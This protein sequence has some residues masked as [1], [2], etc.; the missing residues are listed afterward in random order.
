MKKVLFALIIA[1]ALIAVS[2]SDYNV[3]NDLCSVQFGRLEAKA[4]SSGVTGVV[5]AAENLYWTYTAKK[6]E[7]DKGSKTGE[8]RYTAQEITNINSAEGVQESEKVS[9]DS[10]K[11][12]PIKASGAGYTETLGGFA[13]GEWEF[14]IYGYLEQEHTN[15]IYKGT[16][17]SAHLVVNKVATVAFNVEIQDG[18][19]GTLITKAPGTVL[20]ADYTVTLKSATLTGATMPEHT[21][22]FVEPEG[23]ADAYIATTE[24][25]KQGLW[26]LVYQFED[27]SGNSLGDD[28]EVDAL[29]LNGATTTVTL[30]YDGTLCKWTVQSVTT[31][32]DE[33]RIVWTQ[34]YVPTNPTTTYPAVIPKVGEVLTYGTYPANY[35]NSSGSS[36]SAGD[37]AGKDVTW[38]V[39]AVENGRALVVSEKVLFYM[40]PKAEATTD[41]TSYIYKWSTNDINTYLNGNFLTDYGLSNVKIPSVSHT[42]EAGKDSSTQPAEN[43]TEKVFLLSKAEAENASYFADNVARRVADLSGSNSNWLLRSPSSNMAYREVS[44]G[45]WGE[46][47]PYGQG[48]HLYKG[49]RPAF[50]VTY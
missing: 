47:E 39:L 30:Q 48:M 31:P 37:Y 17:T 5:A 18:S 14:T 15:L 46:M 35:T 7:N 8:T 24:N 44:V 38:K 12:T 42:T 20:D 21:F 19:K 16:C 6:T 49:V 23:G 50:W 29:I 1:V 22:T 10:L 9:A 43:S 2:C 28:L 4:G 27:K 25:V 11:E 32:Q 45:T 3:T 41:D 13:P 33:D 40:K 34:E 36:V 26:K